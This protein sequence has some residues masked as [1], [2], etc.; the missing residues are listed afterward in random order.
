MFT[1]YNTG[2]IDNA[3][4]TNG[5]PDGFTHHHGFQVRHDNMSNAWGFQL[6]GSYHPSYQSLYHRSVNA[7]T[8]SGWKEI[9][10]SGNDGSGSGLDADLL[11]GY[12][13]STTHN[14]ANT[15]PIRDANGYLN[16]GYINTNIGTEALSHDWTKV[17]ASTDNYIRPYGKSDFK[18]RMGLTKSDYD[19]MDYSTTTHYHTGANSHNDTTFDGLLQRGCG[20]ID[21]WNGGAG[22][23]PVG[24]H[25]N[26]FQALHYG[27]GSS[28]F[29]GMQM[30]MSAGNPSHTF[31]RGWWANGGSGYGWQKIW[32]DGNDGSGSGLDADLLDGL[33]GTSFLR[34]DALTYSSNNI[35]RAN[36]HL[37]H[38]VGGYN[39]VGGNS[40][41]PNPIYSIGT[42]YLPS[43]TSLQSF[44]GIGFAH[45]NL[46]G[47]GKTAGWGL[48]AADAGTVTFTAGYSAGTSGIGVWSQGNF[49]STPQGTL[50]GSSNDGSGSGLDADT[51]DSYEGTTYVG[52]R[53]NS[54][55]QQDT[56][57]RANGAYGLYNPTINDFHLWANNESSYGG[58]EIRGSRN[59]YYGIYFYGAG[60][61]SNAAQHLM[62]DSSGN[63]G[64]WSSSNS[65]D[66]PFYYHRSNNCLSITGSTGSSSY[67]L[68]VNGDVYATGN[69]TAYSDRRVKENIVPIND[70]L[71]K[72]NSLQGVYYN[73][74]DDEEKKKEIGFIAQ[75]VNEVAPELVTY[76]EDVDQYGVKYGNTTALL[77]E[78]VKELT[79]QVKDLKQEIKEIKN[80]K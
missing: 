12:H 29:H 18:V 28:Y 25:W 49:V 46:W 50:W 56:W 30:A 48:Y 36:H 65:G 53:G 27:N 42:S 67:E 44:Y 63:G 59:G 6:M 72:V 51:L 80:A 64:L 11:D 43:A 77:V 17:Y 54:Y 26:G 20:F 37:G 75:D 7:G 55:Y 35:G 79:Q 71:E 57:I 4:G 31:L 34:S 41:N 8:W 60:G 78:A 52:K 13:A 38:L 68:Y 15:V 10:D 21:N 3:S 24:S 70:A 58:M 5:N 73:K 40:A 39:N 9:W 66:W 33:Q 16:V 2:F 62:F 74:I 23:P 61:T 32:T 14:A 47:S 22:K 69:I 76:A 45:P 1:T 19:R